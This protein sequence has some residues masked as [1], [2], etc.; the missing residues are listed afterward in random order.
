MNSA[1]I[2]FYS[3]N[4]VAAQAGFKPSD[5]TNMIYW[6]DYTDQS[7]LD[8]DTSGVTSVYRVKDKY[9]GSYQFI[10]PVKNAQPQIGNDGKNYILP[11]AAT[12]SGLYATI[13]QVAN[14]TI[15][16][17]LK[18]NSGSS[19]EYYIEHTDGDSGFIYP[20]GQPSTRILQLR[21]ESSKLMRAITRYPW[22]QLNNYTAN[23][24]QD[25][26]IHLI[27]Y[28][29]KDT[30]KTLFIDGVKVLDLTTGSTDP[31]SG[32]YPVGVSTTGGI[33]YRAYEQFRY[34]KA[35]TDQEATD[36]YNYFLS[37]YS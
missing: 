1:I 7:S 22:A 28:R 15:S 12:G 25:S 32:Q 21:I 17:I 29:N 36:I 26:N 37:K 34:N 14:Y 23:E 24:I 8:L 13:S 2:N 10:Q 20:F 9:T 4:K 5:I 18:Y 31:I 35:I 27:I 11:I 6:H 3:Q 30:Q 16:S 33:R 19:G